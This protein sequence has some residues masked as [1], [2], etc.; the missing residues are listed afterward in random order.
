M[1]FKLYYLYYFLFLLSLL[2]F[3]CSQSD[4]K[5]CDFI[6]GEAL[7]K[8]IHVKELCPVFKSMK[9]DSVCFFIFNSKEKVNNLSDVDRVAHSFRK[10]TNSLDIDNFIILFI[11]NDSEGFW[12]FYS[13][14]MD[15]GN[16][17]E[18]QYIFDKYIYNEIFKKKSQSTKNFKNVIFKCKEIFGGSSGSGQK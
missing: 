12:T 6:A 9:N 5:Q 2:S 3:K 17:L 4:K 16:N 7:G 10:Q 11:F 1:K 15:E 18:K 14:P 13:K 8:E